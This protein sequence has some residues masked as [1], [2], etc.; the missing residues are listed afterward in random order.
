MRY[1][2]SSVMGRMDLPTAVMAFSL[3]RN[4]NSLIETIG[5]MNKNIS[6][7]VSLYSRIC[8]ILSLEEKTYN[9]NYIEKMQNSISVEHVSF[10]YDGKKT[11]LDDISIEIPKNSI[12]VIVGSNGSGKSTLLK[13]LSGAYTAPKGTVSYESFIKYRCNGQG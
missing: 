9:R 12:S 3:Q 10:S 13:I 6:V 7:N 1:S 2:V 4:I 8:E 5:N 11:I